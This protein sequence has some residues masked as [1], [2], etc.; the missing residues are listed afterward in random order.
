MKKLKQ[1]VKKVCEATT[2][3]VLANESGNP[4]NIVDENNLLKEANQ[5]LKKE[6][7]ATQR[8]A[9]TTQ[10]EL[11]QK[12]QKVQSE[13]KELENN[14]ACYN[15]HNSLLESELKSLKNGNREL[16]NRIKAS[17]KAFNDL[18]YENQQRDR[19][20]T[21]FAHRLASL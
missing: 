19:A 20:I 6:L 5:N 2:G 15:Q 13:V 18:K 17:T 1:N 7:K 14:V 21:A 3:L 10:K 4:K 16:S 9:K 11:K 12:N 8:E